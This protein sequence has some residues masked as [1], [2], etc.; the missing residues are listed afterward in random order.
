MLALRHVL[1]ALA[2]IGAAASAAGRVEAQTYPDRLIKMVVPYP[3][4]EPISTLAGV[5]AENMRKT[6]S[7]P[8]VVEHVAGAGGS[9][10]VARVARSAPDGYT[11]S[12]GQWTSHV[13]A[14]A[15]YGPYGNRLDQA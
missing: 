3:A 7:R 12:F 5:L 2:L 6:L 1:C 4:G 15:M 8:V 10:A 13:A 9:I 14:S 11:L